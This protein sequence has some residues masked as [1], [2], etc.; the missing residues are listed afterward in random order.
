M[1]EVR[2]KGLFGGDFEVE[3]VGGVILLTLVLSLASGMAMIA[4]TVNPRLVELL[5]L[6]SCVLGIAC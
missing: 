1:S 3:E 2:A 4:S 5:E 6:L